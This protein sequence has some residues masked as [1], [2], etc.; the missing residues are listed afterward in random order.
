[1]L[2]ILWIK[3]ENGMKKNE[4]IEILGSRGRLRN[5]FT[6]SKKKIIIGVH[7]NM[8]FGVV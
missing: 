8:V 7:G 6:N 4:K 1:M 3:S 5:T 2:K